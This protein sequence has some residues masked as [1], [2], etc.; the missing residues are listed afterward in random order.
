M[1][2][3]S[4]SS[5]YWRALILG[6]ITT[7]IEIGLIFV[8]DNTHINEIW[9]SYTPSIISMFIAFFG[10]KYWTFRNKIG[11]IQL[12]KQCLSY[13]ILEIITLISVTYFLKLIINRI[14][15]YINKNK[16]QVNNMNVLFK[17]LFKIDESNSKLSIIS[18]ILIKQIIVIFIFN[19]ISFPILESYIFTEKKSS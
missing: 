13:F 19:F 7:V 1:T 18:H 15:Q 14:N 10:Q 16:L 9:K 17:Q 12:I 2:F 6:I 4:K 8:L 11:G 5:I 3:L